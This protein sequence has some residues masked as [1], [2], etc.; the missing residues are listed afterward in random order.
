MKMGVLSADFQLAPF[1]DPIPTSMTP[2]IAFSTQSLQFGCPVDAQANASHDARARE[3]KLKDYYSPINWGNA[4]LPL[5][6]ATYDTLVYTRLR[7]VRVGCESV[8]WAG[9]HLCGP[10]VGHAR[11]QCKDA[12]HQGYGSG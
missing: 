12:S 1:G 9:L 2:S 10:R 5:I 4:C 6:S 8:A 11:R 7:R 3:L